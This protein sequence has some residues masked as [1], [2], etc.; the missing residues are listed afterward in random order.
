MEKAILILIQRMTATLIFLTCIIL[1]SFVFSQITKDT[2][3]LDGVV[4]TASKTPQSLGNVTQKI[5]I[6]SSKQI[7]KDISGNR[8]ITEVLQNQPGNSVSVLSRN[9][10]NWGTYGGIGPKYSTFM[11]QGLPVD[12]FIDPMSLDLSAISRIEVQRGPASVLYSNYLSQDFAGNQSPLAGTVNLVLKEKFDAPA[13]RFSTSY[14]SYNTLNG[15]VY[16]QDIAKNVYYYAGVN[17]EMSDYTDYGT[18]G[19][20]LNMQKNPEYRKTKL[21]GGATWFSDDEKQKFTVFVNKTM[22]TGDAGRVYRGFDNNYGVINTGYSLNLS[23]NVGLQVHMGYRSYERTW[24]ESHFNKIDSLSSNNG[25]VQHIIPADI[26]LTVKHGKANILTA[27]MDY[28]GAD[29]NTYTDPLAGYNTFGNKSTA[30][31]SGVYVQEELH[32][33]KLIARGGGRFNY[34]RN[35]IELV[36]GGAPGNASQDWNKFLYSAGLRYNVLKTI[37]LFANIGN[38]FITPGLKSVGG[39]IQP[40]D[41][42]HSGQLPNPNLKPESGLGIDAGIDWQLPFNI[43]ISARYYTISVNDAI[44]ENTVRQ[45]PS[46]SQSVNAG[47]T[48]SN[49]FE[50]EIKQNLNEQF[51]WFA[52]FTSMKTKIANQYDADQDGGTVPFSPEMLVNAGFSYLAPF[53]LQITPSLNYNDGFYDSSSKSGRSKFV[54]GV[55]LNAYVSQIIVSNNKSKVSCFGQFYNLTN[56][57]YEMPWQFQNTGFSVMGGLKVEF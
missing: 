16:H 51:S 41:T 49:G 28:Q 36:N 30:L 29:Y 8:N 22:H 1:P 37:S 48:T 43:Q 21:Y 53:G 46:Q 10:A 35:N 50:T 56:N 34:T 15:Q 6:L 12:A 14:G 40:G 45:N 47:K 23:K 25:A 39:T 13:T 57:R 44:V 9:D 19:S 31:Q 11:L 32:I 33:G 4:I 17:Y 54:P 42:E 26:L 38:S 18:E 5:D 3:F 2:T 27:G 20:W 24:Q 55:L 52:N 7:E